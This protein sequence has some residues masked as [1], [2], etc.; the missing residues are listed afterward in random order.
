MDSSPN[1]MTDPNEMR[2]FQRRFATHASVIEEEA[3]KAYASSQNISGAG[4]VGKAD[5][6]SLMTVGDLHQA[7]NNI[8][9][10]MQFTSDGLGRDADKYEEAERAAQTGLAR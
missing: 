8:R 5:A 10:M 7:F 9:D 3:K 6:T 1:L 2:E 4:W